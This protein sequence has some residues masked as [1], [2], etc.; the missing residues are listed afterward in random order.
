[1]CHACHWKNSNHKKP[2]PEEALSVSSGLEGREPVVNEDV[3]TGVDGA[4]AEDG[5]WSSTYIPPQKALPSKAPLIEP[6]GGMSLEE[7]EKILFQYPV[8]W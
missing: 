1:M 2:K 7:Q 6:E 8:A 5:V 3:K 4:E